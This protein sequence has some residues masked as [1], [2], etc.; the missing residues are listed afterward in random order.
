MPSPLD[1]SQVSSG[2]GKLHTDVVTAAAD[3]YIASGASGGGVSPDVLA[4]T[5]AAPSTTAVFTS[6]GGGDTSKT[7]I[8]GTYG[9][10]WTGSSPSESLS[11]LFKVVNDADDTDIFNQTTNTYVQVTALSSG[12]GAGFV[13]SN[14]TLTFSPAIPTGTNYRVYYSKQAILSSLPKE[15]ASFLTIRRASERVRFPE[16]PRVG[17][18]PT[19]V[20]APLDIVNNPYPDP[21]MAQWKGLIRGTDGTLTA[22]Q[23]G[24]AGF[25]YVGR[26]KN[27][28]DANDVSLTGHQT[29][30]F[31]AVYEKEI[32]SATLASQ[33][34]LTKVDPSLTAQVNPTGT[35]DV[36]QLNLSDYFRVLSPDR[37]ALRCGI[38]MLEL[39]FSNGLKE[40]FIIASLDATDVKRAHLVTLGGAVASFTSQTV[41]A[42]WIRPA[43]FVGGD[44]GSLSGSP[45][46]YKGFGHLVAGSITVTPD[47]EIIQEPPFFAAGT[48]EPARAA[49][50]NNFW[51]IKAFSWGG[52]TQNGAAVAN[53]GQRQVNGELWGDGSIQS[54]GGRIVGLQSKRPAAITVSTNTSYSWNPFTNSFLK[55]SLT[56]STTSV[57]TLTL[58]SNYT[59]ADGDEISIIILNSTS[60]GTAGELSST[61]WPTAFKFSAND[62]NTVVP[63]GS[64]IKFTGTCTG[65][66]Y[67]MTRTDYQP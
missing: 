41:N 53:I 4:Q 30:A 42:R 10:F 27:V 24:S 15:L 28:N 18:A 45:F 14:L 46:Y 21:Y 22:Q 25:V 1:A 29:A 31:L 66:F 63:T 55:V 50:S 62:A 26:K 56:G 43:M 67:Y 5:L 23:S 38:D 13:S 52:Y 9:P 7:L 35:A 61:I 64:V 58:D 49:T 40:V 36:V 51:N 33:T 2:P 11:D 3:L 19:S 44:G 37:T 8:E 48:V 6:S 39:T 47:A 32:T 57:L 12:I 20:A 54:Y 59:A 34:V 65:G 60:T 17:L 16:F